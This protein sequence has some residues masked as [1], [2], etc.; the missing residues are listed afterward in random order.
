MKY[1]YVVVGAGL[2]GSV[3]AHE[4][5]KAGKKVIVIEKREHIGGNCYSHTYPGTDIIA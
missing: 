2:F 3:F 1:D 5:N 4:A